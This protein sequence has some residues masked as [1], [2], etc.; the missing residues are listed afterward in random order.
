MDGRKWKKGV[1]GEQNPTGGVT[2]N[3]RKSQRSKVKQ[4]RVFKLRSLLFWLVFGDED[5]RGMTASF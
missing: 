4:S 3:R 1:V 5:G 2:L